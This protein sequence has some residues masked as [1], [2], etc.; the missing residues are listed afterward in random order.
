MDSYEILNRFEKQP[1]GT[2][3]CLEPVTVQT[4]HGPVAVA[5]G[6]AF[7]YGEKLDDVD[8]AELLERLGAQH[9]S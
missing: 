4:A 3:I 1:D 7:H 9:G 5:A 6:M 2:W 8:V